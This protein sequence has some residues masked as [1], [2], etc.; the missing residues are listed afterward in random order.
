MISRQTAVRALFFSLLLAPLALCTRA[1]SQCEGFG[2]MGPNPPSLG[3]VYWTF[4]DSVSACPAGDSLFAGRPARLRITVYYSDGFD[5]N[6]V[7]VPPESIWVTVATIPAAGNLKVNDEGARTFADDST[8]SGGTTRITVPSFSGCGKCSLHVF[9]SGVEQG[10]K[11]ATVRTADSDGNGRVDSEQG[12]PGCDLNYDGIFSQQDKF[13]RLPH[14]TDWHRNAL[15]GT[16]VRRTNLS[17]AEG[18]PGAIGES[19]L[20]WSPSGRWLSY[21]IHGPSGTHCHVFLVPSSPSIGD[22]PKQFTWYPDTSDYDPTWSP[23]N[24]EIAFGRA[25]YRIMRKGI[26]GVNPDTTERLV[27]QSGNFD[28]HGDLTPAISPDGQWVAFARLDQATADYHL[29]KVPTAG[30][31]ATQLTFTP[32]VPDQY[33]NWSP[34]GEW[35]VFD[36]EIGYPNPHIAYK[37]KANQSAPQDTT[38]Y[39]VYSAGADRDAATPAF[40]PDNL[41]VTMGVGTHSQTILDVVT[42]TLDPALVTPKPIAN[43]PDTAFAIHGLHPVLSPKISPDGTR[44]GLRSRQIWAAR[45]NMNLPPRFTQVEGQS[46]HDTTA[47]YSI[48]AI[49]G[50][51]RT[52]TVTATDPESDQVTYMASFLEPGMTFDP[53]TRT[54]TWPNVPGPAGNKYYVK[55]WVT[56]TS[57]GTDAI[58]VEIVTVAGLSAAARPEPEAAEGRREPDGP[59]PT[60]GPFRLTSLHV[61]GITANLS[62][63]DVTGRRVAVVRGPSGSQLVWQGKDQSDVPVR[64]GVYL[65]RMEV[66]R[67]RQEGKIVVVR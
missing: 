25:D 49:V 55:F 48:N 51:T 31:T 65:Y 42:R 67:Q 41:I 33:P 15:H 6:R 29:W 11:I 38:T 36:R 2:P 28:L 30:G 10:V 27:V 60:R 45:R 4:K 32:G 19:Q 40:S 63:F 64:A 5:C 56:T 53:G 22:Q 50:Q 54:L 52:I 59:N 43:Y 46:V 18:Q 3:N 37:V 47:M 26:L 61:P 20:F 7:G 39:R 17:H 44:L 34:D 14:V 35:I 13:I 8:D 66:G 21:T 23:L 1:W 16:P 57:G 58:I 62:I 12:S 9:V 24:T